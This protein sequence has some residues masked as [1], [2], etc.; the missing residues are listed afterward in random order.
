MQL[1]TNDYYPLRNDAKLL[2]SVSSSIL[3]QINRHWDGRSNEAKAACISRMLRVWDDPVAISAMLD[4]L[5][6][7]DRTALAII[8]AHGG[9]IRVGTLESI[10]QVYGYTLPQPGRPLSIYRSAGSP[11]V[12][13]LIKRG[14]VLLTPRLGSYSPYGDLKYANVS[15]EETVYTDSRILQQVTW[16]VEV[17]P[18]TITPTLPVS[19]SSVRRPHQVMLDLLAVM[20]TLSELPPLTLTKVLA[21]RNSDYRKFLKRMGWQDLQLIDGLAFMGLGD[22]VLATWCHLGWLRRVEHTLMLSLTPDHFARQSLTDLVSKLTGAFLDVRNWQ[23][24]DPYAYHLGNIIAARAMVFHALRALPDAAQWYTM[25]ELTVALYERVGQC[26][27]VVPG[28]RQPM[29]AT[30]DPDV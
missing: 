6:T 22:A 24:V 1:R 12:T 29:P 4:T 14:W 13:S 17:H 2:E 8:M 20:R 3:A 9:V 19:S 26:Q 21:I 5:D 25:D 30:Q 18:L 27:T 11:Y 28:F 10:L 16:P 23:E 15:P 7:L